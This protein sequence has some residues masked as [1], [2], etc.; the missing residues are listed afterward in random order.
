MV[1]DKLLHLNKIGLDKAK[2]PKHIAINIKGHYAWAKK[3]KK[4][5][6]E[7]YAN[8]FGVMK[9]L[10]KDQI[11]FEIPVVSLYLLSEQM[12]NSEQFQLYREKLVDFLSELR[13][14]Q[15]IHENKVKISVW[16]KWYNLPSNIVEHIKFLIDETKDYDGFF[17]NLCI[18]YNGQE[19]IVDA[20]KL[21][22]RKVRAEKL[23][24]EAI[25][26]EL[27]KENLYCS[28]FLPPDLIIITGYRK[29]LSGLLL[30]DAAFARL[31]FANKPWPEFKADDL[32]DA[33]KFY[34]KD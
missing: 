26:K 10:I 24:P 9:R 31:Y 29:E 3:R 22:A 34:Q 19:E 18:N 15:L 16:G 27:L 28:A 5:I 20:C 2:M 8:G 7:T 33:L 17:L 13:E 1:I 30:W 6:A 4:D 21:I 32:I 23:E 25:S 12:P 14:Y 11:D